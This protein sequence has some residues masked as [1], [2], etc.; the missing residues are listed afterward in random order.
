[1]KGSLIVKRQDELGCGPD[2]E[3]PEEFTVF[4]NSAN[5]P[6]ANVLP[7]EARVTQ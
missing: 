2:C 5:G 1:L 6:W 7:E 4:V 3:S